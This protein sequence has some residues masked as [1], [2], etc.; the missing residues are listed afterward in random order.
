MPFWLIFLQAY[1]ADTCFRYKIGVP[2]DLPSSLIPPLKSYL[3]TSDI[4][5]LAQTL[6]IMALLLELSPSTTYPEVES[7][8]LKD[9]Y[10]IAH[11]PLVSGAAFDSVLAFFAALVEADMQV[12]THVV[13]NLVIYVEKAPKSDASHSNV[14]RCV[15]QVVKSQRGIAAGT[16]AEF[17][18]HLKV[19]S[20]S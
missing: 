11:S 4:S 1:Y 7:E 20:T 15:G 8:L 3:T 9:I 5:L 2:A 16:V 10:A 18:R 13:P 14:A 17:S 19:C 6:N 12:A